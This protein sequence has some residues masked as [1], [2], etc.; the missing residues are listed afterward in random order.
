MINIDTI[1]TFNATKAVYEIGMKGRPGV[2]INITARI[3]DGLYLQT[4]SG[5]AKAAVES[6][7]KHL[8]VELGPQN[9]RVVAIAPGP[10]EGTEG[11][12]RLG[13]KDPNDRDAFAGWIP[14]QRYGQKEDINSAAVFLAS[15]A[16][17]YITGT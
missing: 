11:T 12:D 15:D 1:G 6:M 16:A 4:H 9:I 17:S 10:I 8:A 3:S 5:S 13:G 14:M 2:I 7:T